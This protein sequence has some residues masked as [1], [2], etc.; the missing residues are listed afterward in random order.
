[1]PSETYF[2][3]LGSWFCQYVSP[4][5]GLRWELRGREHL[6]SDSACIIVSNHQSS[7]DVLGMF[8]LWP[9]MEKCTV[10]GKKEI[11]YAWPVGLAAWLC[12]M[13]FIDRSYSESARSVLNNATQ[14]LKDNKVWYL[15]FLYFLCKWRLPCAAVYN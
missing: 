14:K 7:L 3:R 8:E 2:C 13:I 6:E 10:V 12:G 15:L 5:V 1:M 4:L 9:V 11:F